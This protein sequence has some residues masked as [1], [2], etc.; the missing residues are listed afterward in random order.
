MCYET[1]FTK[2]YESGVIGIFPEV[3]SKIIHI[4]QEID[5]RAMIG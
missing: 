2:F 5:Q 4:I 1:S 3:D